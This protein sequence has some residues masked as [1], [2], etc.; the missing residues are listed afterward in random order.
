MNVTFAVRPVASVTDPR[1]VR[2]PAETGAAVHVRVPPSDEFPALVSASESERRY[3]YGGR[4]PAIVAWTG[5]AAPASGSAVPSATERFRPGATVTVMFAATATPEPSTTETGRVSG[6]VRSNVT[7]SAM[8]PSA[9]IDPCAGDSAVT[10]TTGGTDHANG[11]VPSA[12][13]TAT[14][15]GYPTSANG[16]LAGA[17][18]GGGVAR[19]TG[20][21]PF[22]LRFQAST[23][24]PDT[25]TVPGV[26]GTTASS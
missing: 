9:A 12:T 6:P 20:V 26:S 7:V 22:E 15:V 24:E 4:P 25:Q 13:P 14:G 18:C 19:P 11:G 21:S 5:S 16:T 23:T 2:Y 8:V 10:P 3:R 1:N 17:S